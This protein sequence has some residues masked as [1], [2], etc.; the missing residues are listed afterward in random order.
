MN[1]SNGN[2]MEN[3]DNNISIEK[4]GNLGMKK[5]LQM[6]DLALKGLFLV[7]EIFCPMD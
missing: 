5:Y 6:V 7:A 4:G 3:S 1:L 2:G